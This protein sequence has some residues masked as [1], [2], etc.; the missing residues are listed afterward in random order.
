[1]RDYL[2][3]NP[4]KFHPH[5]IWNDGAL[6]FLEVVAPEKNKKKKKN[7]NNKMSSDMTGAW[8]KYA[9]SR[10]PNSVTICKENKKEY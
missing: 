9:D 5:P 2:K 7:K 1:M 6:R 8:S 4:A 10:G 3:N